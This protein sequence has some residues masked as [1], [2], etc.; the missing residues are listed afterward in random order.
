MFMKFSIT[1]LNGCDFES[2]K[3]ILQSV[4][5]KIVMPYYS[6]VALGTFELELLSKKY[7]QS[8]RLKTKHFRA[9][10][11]RKNFSRVA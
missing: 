3:Y 8:Y 1:I 10:F 4:R 9:C 5:S 11:Y 6:P 7:K 2:I